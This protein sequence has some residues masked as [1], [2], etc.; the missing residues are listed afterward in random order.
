MKIKAIFDLYTNTTKKTHFILWTTQLFDIILYRICECGKMKNKGQ[1]LVEFIIILPI[2]LLLLL[3]IIDFGNIIYKKYTLE[4][5]LDQIVNLV[6]QKN[7]AGINTYI[8]QNN[9][10]SNI[11]AKTD[12][13][14]ITLTKKITINTPG[15]NKILGKNYQIEAKRVI[16]NE[17]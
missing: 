11:E 10:T 1:A 17:P 7:E 2:L 14:S 6:K 5:D 4:N 15:L 12:T 8:K 3:G 13:T 9:L 16:P